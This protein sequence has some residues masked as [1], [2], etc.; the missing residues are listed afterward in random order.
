MRPYANLPPLLPPT[1]CCS[2][3]SCAGTA[4][5]KYAVV[6]GGRRL[7]A[8]QLRAGEGKIDATYAVPC[9]TLGSGVDAA[10][11]SLAENVLREAMH[12]AD[13]FEASA[14]SSTAA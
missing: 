7:A 14:L 13:E 4:R 11:I 3:L 9:Q 6:A 2:P 8:L 1:A 5:G 12:P 10:E